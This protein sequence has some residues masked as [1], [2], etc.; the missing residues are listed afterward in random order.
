MAHV[1]TCI[2]TTAS[3]AQL[4]SARPSSLSNLLTVHVVGRLTP[5]V[6]AVLD[7]MLRGR[8]NSGRDQLLLVLDHPDLRDHLRGL[9]ES[10]CVVVVPD[11]QTV[12]T[13]LRQLSRA[14]V[15]VAM[16]RPLRELHLHG[17]IPALAGIR[18]LR[19]TRASPPEV[20]FIPHGSRA[21]AGRGMPRQ[22][23]WRM[24][25]HALGLD[26]RTELPAAANVRVPGQSMAAVTPAAPA[27]Q[28]VDGRVADCFFQAGRQE[29]RRP[30]ITCASTDGNRDAVDRYVR[31][32]ILLGDE[33]MGMGF[34]WVGPD[35]PAGNAALKAAGIGHF[36]DATLNESLRALRFSGT[37]VYV[38]PVEERGFPVRLAEA[39]A[40]GL[41]CVAVDTPAHRQLIEDGRTGYLCEDLALMLER[42]AMLVDSSDLRR[43][44]GS[45][46]VETARR[47]F[48]DGSA[49]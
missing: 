49:P 44:I 45:A 40:S 12:W 30:L 34:N 4:S 18:A 33:R 17:V 11:A 20:S 13:R 36:A 48:S 28:C 39:M 27:I 10:V 29:A 16:S 43:R 46:A 41:P 21:L 38:A 9:P 25:R 8:S 35:R 32:A 7:S 24:L 26:P 31:I 19:H 5:P 23:L 6:A 14:L 42:V 47:R 15:N 22:L 1:D 3:I 37:W 2:P